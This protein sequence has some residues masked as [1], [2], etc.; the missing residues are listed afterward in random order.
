MPNITT[1]QSQKISQTK[2]SIIFLFFQ[3]SEWSIDILVL[4]WFCK[5]CA[6]QFP[7]TQQIWKSKL[8]RIPIFQQHPRIFVKVRI[9]CSYSFCNCH[10]IMFGRRLGLA[11]TPYYETEIKISHCSWWC[12]FYC[13]AVLRGVLL[14]WH[15]VLAST[16]CDCEIASVLRWKPGCVFGK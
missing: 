1:W 13:T 16:S 14:E 15:S 8:K 10:V 4:W 12:E 9:W 6:G 11:A 2:I 5:T 3:T 7:V